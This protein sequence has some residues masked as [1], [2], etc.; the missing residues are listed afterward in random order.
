MIKWTS[1]TK[2]DLADTVRC[3]TVRLH[4]RYKP[5]MAVKEFFRIKIQKS[6]EVKDSGTANMSEELFTEPHAMVVQ[7]LY[8]VDKHFSELAKAHPISMKA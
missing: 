3:I 8:D 4:V 2:R 7:E 6:R 5:A 1:P